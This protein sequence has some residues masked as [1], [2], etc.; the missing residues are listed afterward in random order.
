MRNLALG[1]LAGPLW[2]AAMV[3]LCAS[4]RPEYSHAHQFISELGATDTPHASLMNYAGF[5]PLGLLI[6]GFGVSIRTSVPRHAAITVGALGVILFGVGIAASGLISCDA[7]CPQTGGSFENAVHQV[8][9]PACFVTGSVAAIALGIGF[10]SVPRLRSLSLYS[11][12]S[13][14][15]AFG[16]LSAVASTLETRVLTGLWQRLLLTVLF[17]WC[18]VVGLRLFREPRVG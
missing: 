10:R 3:T 15:L 4:L 8:I 14:V 16:F 13:G 5:L 1:G 11:I 18:A 7:G 2:F 12:A 6:A 17:T 9:G